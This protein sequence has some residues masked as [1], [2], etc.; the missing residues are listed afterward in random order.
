[1]SDEQEWTKNDNEAPISPSIFKNQIDRPL[2]NRNKK[3]L[4]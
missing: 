4:M 3:P 2:K 1:M